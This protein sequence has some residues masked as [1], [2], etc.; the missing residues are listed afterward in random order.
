VLWHVY[1]LRPGDHTLS[2]RTTGKADSRSK[3]TRIAIQ[4]AVV[5]RAL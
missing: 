1:D 5:Y 4:T 3:G 2:L